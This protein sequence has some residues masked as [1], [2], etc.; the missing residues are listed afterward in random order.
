M[1]TGEKN[2]TR[3][4][5]LERMSN[6]SQSTRPKNYS[7]KSLCSLLHMLLKDTCMCLQDE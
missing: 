7:R 5:N 1:A 3:P 2:S 4:R 6:F